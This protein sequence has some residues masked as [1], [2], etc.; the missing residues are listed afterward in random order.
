MQARGSWRGACAARRG[1]PLRPPMGLP[2]GPPTHPPT[3]RPHVDLPAGVHREHGCAVAHHPHE[4]NVRVVAA[5]HRLPPTLSGADLGTAGKGGNG[6]GGGV[7]AAGGRGPGGDAATVRMRHGARDHDSPYRFTRPIC[8][9]VYAYHFVCGRAFVSPFLRVSVGG[10]GRPSFAVRPN[11][12]QVAP[13]AP[14]RSHQQRPSNG[15][16]NPEGQG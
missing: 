15:F 2:V 6:G 13:P 8:T 10:W 12:N 11:V 5:E 7:G 9:K 1:R 4:H 3:H 14:G 16:R